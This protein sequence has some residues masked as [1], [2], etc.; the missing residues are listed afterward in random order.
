ML[1]LTPTLVLCRQIKLNRTVS[2]EVAK[3][4]CEGKWEEVDSHLLGA[5]DEKVKGSILPESCLS[6]TSWG[7]AGRD[8]PRAL[9]GATKS[10]TTGLKAHDNHFCFPHPTNLSDPLGIL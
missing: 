3:T 6:Q 8:S 7:P 4:Q 1:F 5:G 9:M 2:N 10:E